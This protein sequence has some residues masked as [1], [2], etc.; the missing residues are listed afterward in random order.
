MVIA[1]EN[2]G[3]ETVYLGILA[4]SGVAIIAWG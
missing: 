3:N 1:G 2:A 4:G